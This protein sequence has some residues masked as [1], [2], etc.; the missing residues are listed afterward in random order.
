MAAYYSPA[1]GAFPFLV[2]LNKQST[3]TI[4]LDGFKVLNHA[5]PEEVSISLVYMLE[6]FAREITTF[7]TILDSTIQE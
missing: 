2:L 3:Y 1:L 5:H 7:I 6:P 4:I